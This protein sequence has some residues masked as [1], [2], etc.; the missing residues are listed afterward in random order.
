VREFVSDDITT[1]AELHH[2][3][4]SPRVRAPDDFFAEL[5]LRSPCLDDA[6]HS[7]VYEDADG[8]VV[9]FLG[10]V[11][12]PLALGDVPVSAA[13]TTKFMVDPDARASMAALLLFRRFIQGPQQLSFSDIVNDQ[14]LPI[15]Q[16]FGGT[17]VQIAGLEWHRHLRRMPSR[18]FESRLSGPLRTCA[19]LGYPLLDGATQLLMPTPRLREPKLVVSALDLADIVAT[20]PRMVDRHVIR[21][22]YNEPSLRWIVRG[23]ETDPEMRLI[24][25]MLRSK[26]GDVVGW[27]MYQLVQE[28]IARVVHMAARSQDMSNVL[29][30]LLWHA[31]QQGATDVFGRLDPLWF[32]TVSD[33]ADVSC[34]F[35]GNSLV[36]QTD[37][38]AL[39]ETVFRGDLFLTPIDGEVITQFRG[40]RPA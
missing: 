39:R 6:V 25:A 34:Q 18:R 24:T 38:P 26:E 22:D 13:F 40:E 21:P 20:M 30:S 11:P 14:G 28:Q 7:L 31:S 17:T 32:P 37:D 27:F 29:D 19:R 12:R 8:R 35:R 10:V 2:K 15:W 5:F 4:M 36:V 3:V 16:A 23:L 1:I 9:G 33:R